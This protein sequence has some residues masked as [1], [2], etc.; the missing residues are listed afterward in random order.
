MI[1]VIFLLTTYTNVVIHC[2]DTCCLALYGIQHISAVK[3]Q[4]I[5]AVKYQHIRQCFRYANFFTFFS[6]WSVALKMN[7][8]F[9]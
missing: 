6:L 4:H 1:S 9:T 8:R 7:L 3:Y 2:K 5:S